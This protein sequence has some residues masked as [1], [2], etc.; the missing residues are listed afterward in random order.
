MTAPV[1]LPAGLRE[2]L[3]GLARRIR[4]L[5]LA[6]GAGWLVLV[7]AL[8][9][10]GAFLADVWLGLGDVALAVILA[11][12]A[13][14]ALLIALVGIILP[15][16]R[17]LSPGAL[18]ALVEQRYPDLG[19]RLTSSALLAG[20]ADP[21]HGSRALVALLIKDTAGRTR[22]LAFG[23]AFPARPTALLLGAAGGALLL[24]LVPGLVWADAYADFT[25][26][27]LSAWS[28]PA[29][30]TL[31][32]SPGDH[33]LA[34]G[35]HLTVTVKV[36]RR[37]DRDPW[38]E[39]C[40]LVTTDAA[41]STSRVPMHSQVA[42]AFTYT[43]GQ[44]Q[45]SL[46]Y[47]VESGRVASD[48]YHIT[49]VEP[50]A[51]APDSPTCRITPPAYVNPAVHP[52]QTRQN[53]TD[54]SILQY[55]RVRLTFRFN[56]PARAARLEVTARG[57]QGKTW[58]LPMTPAAERPEA[59][60]LL[61]AMAVGEYSLTLHTEAEH[62]ITSRHELPALTV[63]GDEPPVFT[64]QPLPAGVAADKAKPVAP[65]DVLRLKVVLQDKV[66]LGPAEVEY[67][68]ND[69]PSCFEKIADGKGALTVSTE[70]RLALA[71]KVKDGDTFR[72]RIRA[73]DNRRLGK[74]ACADADGRPVPAAD[75]EPHV[76]YYPE[77][78]KGQDRW[79]TLQVR[80]GAEPLRKQEILAE[81]DEI[82]R[83]LEAI[84]KRLEGE[85]GQVDKL[86]VAA[87]AHPP[88][89]P[90]QA[91][92][93]EAARRENAGIIGDL[94]DLAKTA[95]A[96]PLQ[97]LAERALE[98][99]ET[100]ML[101]SDEALGRAGDQKA[102]AAGREPFLHKAD[103]ELA[104]ALRRLDDL[105]NKNAELAQ[106]R[107]D[108][109]RM[110]QLAQRESELAKK[111]PKTVGPQPRLDKLRAEQEQLAQDLSRLLEE[112]K[113][114]RKA[115]AAARAGEADKLAAQAGKLAQ[116]QR[117]LAQGEAQAR[118]KQ[119]EWLLGDFAKKQQ[120]L[121]AEADRLAEKTAEAARD[122][123]ARP[124]QTATARAAAEA[125]KQGQA[126][127]AL[128]LQEQAA[129]EMER[130]AADLERGLTL[131]GD[132]RE[133]FR[134]LA[135]AQA[136]LKDRL[137]QEA[138]RVAVK[139]S[140]EILKYL[141]DM[142]RDE[143]T[144]QR[145]AASVPVPKQA[146]P[147]RQAAA[148][149]A[150][151]AADAFKRRDPFQARE[152]MQQA[153]EALE[154]LARQLP[155]PDPA[156]RPPDMKDRPGDAAARR[157]AQEAR[158]LGQA[159]KD[160]RDALRQALT[161]PQP[162]A[163][164]AVQKTQQARQ[165]DLHRQAGELARKMNQLAQSAPTSP[166][167]KDAAESSVRA[168]AAMKQAADRQ[169]NTQGAQQ[170]AAQMLERAAQAAGKTAGSS[171]GDPQ[172][173][174]SQKAGQAAEQGQEQAAQAQAQLR[175]G[176][177]QAA[178]VAMQQAAQALQE[179]AQQAS[180]QPSQSGQRPGRPSGVKNSSGQSAAGPV[181]PDTRLYG[182]DGRQYAGKAW[183]QLPGELRTRIL[184]DLRGRYGEDYAGII[185]RYFEAVADTD[186]K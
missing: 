162:A 56:R 11:G 127:R 120:A 36:E 77:K 140:R 181:A 44:V 89:T 47:H 113:L 180:R 61:P 96:L 79:L 107:L 62:G 28:A 146:E 110:E 91:R 171:K 157:Q 108:Q 63:W 165:E 22:P 170:R 112:S 46:D 136:S 2:Q 8:A 186:R 66:G 57:R 64:Q 138:G 114:F 65:N 26:R 5:R 60:A 119:M 12:L 156:E 39:A 41:G 67:R 83:R 14:T 7:V 148:A 132:P 176:Q 88:L 51:L 29:P 53:V 179:A 160:L 31:Q 154:Q 105:K 95:Q 121:T 1:A 69:G 168:Q 72:F 49:A 150:A 54:L 125:L 155:A 6:R 73:A 90:E 178:Q 149:R 123:R 17:R 24:A 30:F 164:P 104:S 158:R 55:S 45:A 20:T 126:E 33:A 37:D 80:A 177:S 35:R 71:G 111:V 18:A 137:E 58:T 15:L 135:Q 109:M 175:Q 153:Q 143:E 131:K 59:V 134:R 9:F 151:A 32:V 85:R 129:G 103:Q 101:R 161:R 183:G 133:A 10:A 142:R 74:G 19:E 50:V 23:R 102:D 13:G 167:A 34:V 27:L 130:A 169:G 76:I 141:D 4:L 68:V 16:C 166:Q 184:Q 147:A 117:D 3:D 159:Q 173:A 122:L 116:A 124:L 139:S 70:H 98:I 92:G 99:A 97:N 40:Y 42:G 52:E 25:R 38:P 128:G 93:L 43:L 174:A 48:T 94:F 100:E 84:R 172:A 86:R 182:K 78:V 87:T 82:N 145:A 106:D 163:D 115:L 118:Q 21:N 152:E 81:R 185:Q 144:I 75:L